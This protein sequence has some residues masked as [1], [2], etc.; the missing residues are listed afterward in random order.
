MSGIE[1][2]F[3]L[4]ADFLHFI[5]LSILYMRK[6]DLLD[7]SYKVKHSINASSFFF[8]FYIMTLCFTKLLIIQLFWA[9]NVSTPFPQ[10]V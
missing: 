4:E 8:S 6:I 5:A 3:I 1:A 2:V 7:D 10:T 9:F